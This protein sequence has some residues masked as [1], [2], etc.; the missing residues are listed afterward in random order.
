[1]LVVIK[2]TFG[3]FIHYTSYILY[4]GEPKCTLDKF[5][6]MIEKMICEYGVCGT[7]WKKG[8][9]DIEVDMEKIKRGYGL[10]NMQDRA[11]RIGAQ[12]RI[13]SAPGKGTVVRVELS[14]E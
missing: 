13:E 2:L 12:A 3:S 11:S 9:G 7:T 5:E 8:E 6:K 14:V 10:G 1:M 4:H